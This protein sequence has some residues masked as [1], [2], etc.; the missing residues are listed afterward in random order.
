MKQLPVGAKTTF[1]RSN[2]VGTKSPV[3]QFVCVPNCFYHKNLNNYNNDNHSNNIF[4][5]FESLP[6][7]HSNVT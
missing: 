7:P 3:S 4:L 2:I 5:L 6:L 1:L